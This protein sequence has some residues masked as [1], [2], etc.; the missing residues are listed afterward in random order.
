MGYQDPSEDESSPYFEGHTRQPYVAPKK[1]DDE[2]T[3]RLNSKIESKVFLLALKI[4]GM[5]MLQYRTTSDLVPR[6]ILGL[7]N[8]LRDRIF[9]SNFTDIA[10]LKSDMVNICTAIKEEFET[11][12]YDTAILEWIREKLTSKL[13]RR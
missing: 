7:S 2:F 6:L 9:E 10:E 3:Q 13:N 12:E 8:L 4:Q 1:L 5:K 11:T